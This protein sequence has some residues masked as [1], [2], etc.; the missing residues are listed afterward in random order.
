MARQVISEGLR[1][2]YEDAGTGE[3]TLLFLPGWCVERGAFAPVMR[4]IRGQRA[5]ALDWRG[6]GSSDAPTQD[7][8]YDELARDALAVVA[9][10]GAEHVVPVALSHAGWVAIELRRRLGQRVPAIVLLDWMVLG[11]PAPFLDALHALQ[12]ETRWAAA[13]DAIFDRWTAGE[14]LPELI[15][16]VRERMGAYGFEMWARAAREIERAFARHGVPVDALRSLEPP[17]P[18]LH[19]Y[20]QPPDDA[21]LDAQRRF[22]GAHAWFQVRRLDAESHF[23]MFEVPTEIA[24]E[25]DRFVTGTVAASR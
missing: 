9:Q 1:I 3:P 15:R 20:A 23:P 14:T 25:I 24:R 21:Y 6:H 22:A 11:A 12:Q 5:L 10:S 19:L 16:F 4:A 18:A 17:V 7:F 2:D 13:R 8:G